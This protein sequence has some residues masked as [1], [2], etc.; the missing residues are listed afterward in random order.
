[1]KGKRKNEILILIFAAVLAG[2]GMISSRA[3]VSAPPSYLKAATYVS[4]AWVIN[5]WNTESDHIQTRFPII[6]TRSRS[7]IG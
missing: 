7:W 4:D 3:E 5:F 1:M 6:R 2:S